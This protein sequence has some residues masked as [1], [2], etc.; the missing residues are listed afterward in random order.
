MTR[1]GLCALVLGLLTLCSLPVLAQEV[2][3]ELEVLQRPTSGTMK[4]D[5]RL[6]RGRVSYEGAHQG[7]RVWSDAQPVGPETNR[8]RLSG[9]HAGNTLGIRLTQKDALPDEEGG[10]GIVLH[11][12]ERTATF[13]VVIDGDQAVKVDQYRLL[14][15]AAALLP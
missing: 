3:L 4:G 2:K 10:S 14:L 8:Y 7:F 6:V 15:K 1:Q 5:T 11:T 13:Y 12:G 9:S